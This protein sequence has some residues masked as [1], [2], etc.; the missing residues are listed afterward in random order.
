MKLGLFATIIESDFR[1]VGDIYV[2]YMFETFVVY[3]DYSNEIELQFMDDSELVKYTN[4]T[5]VWSR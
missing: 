2:T 3:E 1:L 4:K 5:L